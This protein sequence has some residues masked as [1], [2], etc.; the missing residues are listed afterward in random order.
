MNSPTPVAFEAIP[1]GRL[2]SL[3]DMLKIH[4]QQYIG[5]DLLPEIALDL[6]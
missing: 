1:P 6:R 2:W 3:W 5:F 4:A